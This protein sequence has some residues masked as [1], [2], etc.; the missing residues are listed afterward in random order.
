[1]ESQYWGW[2]IGEWKAK[3]KENIGE[4]K[5]NIDFNI[6]IRKILVN[7]KPILT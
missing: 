6:N 4:W 7:G 5:A 1:M 3:Y 2:K